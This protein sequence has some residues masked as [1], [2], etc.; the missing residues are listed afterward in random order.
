MKI[1]LVYDWLNCIG[2]AER[3]IKTLCKIWPQADIFSSVYDS[4]R[5]IIRNGKIK[6]SFLQSFPLALSK[7][8]L[9]YP[10]LPLAFEQFILDE[11]DIVISVSS[12][13][14]KAIITK[15]ET[16]HLNY[17]L[18]PPRYIW[19][20]DLSPKLLFNP[21]KNLL[22]KHDYLLSKRPDEIISISKNTQKRV[23][24]YYHKDT[25]VIYPGI[26]LKKFLPIKN[27]KR[28]YFLIVSRLVE[29]K[30]IDL[31]IKA[32][33]KNGKRLLIAGTGRQ[34][35]ELQAIAKDN[36]E[37]LG[38]VGEK[39]LINLYQNA[40][41]LINPQEEDFGLAPIESQACGTPV[42]AYGKGGATETVQNGKTGVLFFKQTI[43]DLN[44][45]V[46]QLERLKI[47]SSDCR[48]NA[49]KFNEKDFM[50]LFKNTT[51]KLWQKNLKT[52][53]KT[54]ML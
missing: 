52:N 18:T 26:D 17:C 4:D 38:L 10:I 48:K 50:L 30:K 5:S 1:A 12:G 16:F 20:D 36:V 37:F 44:K 19:C 11:Y 45:A 27:P 14:A 28:D 42:I 41:A 32:F 47:N 2:G 29:Y 46:R 3:V 35:N 25:K 15:P 39:M 13:P 43:S 7:T 21:L 8:Y 49:L 9:Y 31:A 34:I 6:T 24:D 54:F 53:Q 22:K 40:I 23:K 51:E 33:N